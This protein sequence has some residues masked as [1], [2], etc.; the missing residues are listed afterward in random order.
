MQSAPDVYDLGAAERDVNES[1]SA[2]HKHWIAFVLLSV[3]IMATTL[4]ISDFDMVKGVALKLP[5][6]GIDVPL[7]SYAI[8][9]PII[10]LAFHIY[11]LYELL[12]LSRKLTTYEQSLMRAHPVSFF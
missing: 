5:A 6:A 10:Y 1:A 8:A 4:T 9:T 11:L 2:L 12:I 7:I 3:A